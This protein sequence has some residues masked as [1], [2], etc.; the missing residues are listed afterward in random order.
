MAGVELAHALAARLQGTRPVTLV[1]HSIGARVV[2]S[3]LKELYRLKTVEQK[4]FED[5]RRD[6]GETGTGGGGVVHSDSGSGVVEIQDDV[7][8]YENT[9]G[10]GGD[11]E[12]EVEPAVAVEA[13]KKESGF[14]SKW[15][16]KLTS[17][18]NKSE[19]STNSNSNSKEAAEPEPAPRF[20][21]KYDGI[22]QDV[23]ILGAPINST[24]SYRILTVYYPSVCLYNYVYVC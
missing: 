5:E 20:I 14:F 3:C 12:V 11:G 6:K 19:E 9:G 18:T 13:D 10:G 15:K 17:T 7:V 24:V 21:S 8:E 16:A 2:Y 22:I 4:K 23:V 1:G